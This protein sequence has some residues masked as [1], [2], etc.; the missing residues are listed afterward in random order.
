MILKVKKDIL[1][2]IIFVGV[3]VTIFLVISEVALR[4]IENDKYYVWQPGLQKIFHPS[5]DIMPGISGISHFT[6][7]K[8]GLRGDVFT[9]GTYRILAVGGSTTESL[10]LDDTEA[11]P[12]LVQEIL[13]A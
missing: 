11:W 12:Y 2:L 13:N 7:N 1:F 5:P 10:Y 4:A 9:E 6:I 8:F 3:T